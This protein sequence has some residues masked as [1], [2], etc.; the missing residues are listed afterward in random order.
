MTRGILPACHVRPTRPVTQAEL[1]ALYAEAYATSR[2]SRSCPSRRPPSTSSAATCAASTSGSTRGPAACS[3]SA[4]STTW[5]RAPPARRS[6][7]STSSTACPRRPA[8]SSYPLAPVTA[9][10]RRRCPSSRPPTEAARAMRRAAT[11]RA[12][13]PVGR[14]RRGRP[15]SPLPPALPPVEER[16]SCRR[17]SGRGRAAGIKPPA[18]RTW[19]HR[20]ERPRRGRRRLHPQPGRRGAG[21]ALAGPPG[22][23]D[24]GRRPRR[25]SRLGR[26]DRGHGRLRE[27]RHGRRRA[28]PTRSPIADGRGRALAPRPSERAGLSTGRDRHPAAGRDG[29]R[30]D[31]QRSPRAAWRPTTPRWRPSPTRCMTTDT[32]AKGATAPVELPGPDGAPVAV[33]VSRHRQGR[34]H[35]PPAHGDDAARHPDRRRVEPGARSTASSATR[36]S[37]TWNQLSVDGDTSTNDTVFLLA[38]GAAAA[39]PVVPGTAEAAAPRRR[40][41]GRGPLAGPPAGGR[42]RGRHDPHHLPGRAAPRTTHD[43]RAVARSVISSSLVKAAVHGRDPNWGRIAG[44]AGN[45]RLPGEAAARGGR[46]RPPRRPA[47]GPARR[48]WTPTGCGSRS[49]ATSSS[50]AAAPVAFDRDGRPGRDGRPRGAD[51]PGPGPGRAA[52]AR[53]SAAI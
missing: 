11:R 35:D 3:P 53:P 2:S 12:G 33:T 40:D 41:R 34:R 8:S 36:R 44:A 43:A 47:G 22:D 23:A 25:R 20:H 6:R 21:P 52:P 24:R 16:R 49:P 30:R 18:G 39:A 46:P 45:A 15:R 37:R 38:S 14:C 1:D 26:R 13:E 9:R 51:P 5:S 32:T 17:A 7:P 42:R 50:T 28:T 29:G 10:R 48:R 27:R 19:R 4:S 31:R